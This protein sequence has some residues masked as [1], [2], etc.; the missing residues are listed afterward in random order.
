MFA[1]VKSA[2]PG[3]SRPSGERTSLCEIFRLFLGLGLTAFGG[4]AAH[5]SLM[6]IETVER[7]NWMSRERFLDLVGAC[8]LLPGPGST[9]VAMALGYSRRRW[10]GLL[11]A[12]SC[13]I[14][15][16]SFATLGLAWFY[17]RFGSLSAVQGLL[18]GAKP[19]MLAVLAQAVWKLGSS[20]WRTISL[21]CLGIVCG[22]A[23]L[24]GLHPLAILIAAGSLVLLVR[25]QKDQARSRKSLAALASPFS[26]AGLPVGA[27]AAGGVGL[28]SLTAV[29]FKLGVAVFGSGYVL[30]AFLQ[31]DLVDR[32]H[33]ITP[34]QLLDAVTA[35]Q[36]TPG[37]VFATAT[38]LGYLLHGWSGAALATAAIFLPSFVMAGVVGAMADRIRKS[39]LA[40]GFLDGVNVAAV[41]LMASVALPLGRASL[42]DGWTSTLA[43][44]SALLLIRFRINATWLILASAGLGLLLY[45]HA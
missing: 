45:G 10:V 28:L 25:M 39:S 19:V 18:Y 26:S 40:G 44:I 33:W 31:A 3:P 35:G 41:A 1:T 8:N 42:V 20:A 2:S 27:A 17:A 24:L 32:L 37:P 43:G 6:Q 11:V 14:L 4:P 12:G 36:L 7:R 23:A 9:Q 22:A 21:A 5:L 15:P 16:A 34:T 13:F 29:F 30:L 38:F